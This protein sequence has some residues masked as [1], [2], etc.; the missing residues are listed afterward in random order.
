MV[1]VGCVDVVVMAQ[2]DCDLA[3]FKPLCEE[4]LGTELTLLD[5]FEL[6]TGEVDRSRLSDVLRAE[7]PTEASIVRAFYNEN[8]LGFFESV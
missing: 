7:I 8:G 4:M 3:V 2:K 5:N 1:G 6:L